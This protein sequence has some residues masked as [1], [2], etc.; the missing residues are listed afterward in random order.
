M[1]LASGELLALCGMMGS[2]KTATARALSRLLGRRVVHLDEEIVRR[3]GKPVP[4]IFAEE[5]EER[6]R[7]LE[8]EAVAALPPGAIADLGG[9]AFC[10]PQSAAWLLAAGRVVFL[11]V[12]ATEAARRIGGDANRPL[13]VRWEALAADRRPLY[14]RAHL[15]VLT[16]GLTPDE[17][18]RRIIHTLEAL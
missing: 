4:A 3:A 10:D 2:G 11:D 8:R 5:G 12:S 15:T 17:V 13:A 9:G 1:P 18:A 16:D 7:A 14:Q 6:F